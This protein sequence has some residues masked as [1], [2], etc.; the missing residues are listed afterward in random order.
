MVRSDVF[1][2]GRNKGMNNEGSFRVTSPRATID[3]HD[4]RRMAAVQ[5]ASPQ[6]AL[7]SRN[8]GSRPG[9]VTREAI[10][11]CCSLH[12]A[13][14]LVQQMGTA[15]YSVQH[16]VIYQQD[17]LCRFSCLNNA[18]CSMNGIRREHVTG[19]SDIQRMCL[20]CSVTVILNVRRCFGCLV[21][22]WCPRRSVVLV[23]LDIL[24]SPIAQREGIKPNLIWM[25]LR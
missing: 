12:R 13:Y 10:A 20:G 7:S 25:K 1:F 19:R 14:N 15:T 24:T 8:S 11:C 21:H 18:K 23:L 22:S 2:S 17:C 5:N 9:N 3:P 16:S 4:W 6:L